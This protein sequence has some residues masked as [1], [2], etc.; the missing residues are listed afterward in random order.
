MSFYFFAVPWHRKWLIQAK[1][2][3]FIWKIKPLLCFCVAYPGN[4]LDLNL[5]TVVLTIMFSQDNTV[6]S[7]TVENN[8][9]QRSYCRD[10][11]SF[12]WMCETSE[13]LTTHGSEQQWQPSTGWSGIL[14]RSGIL[15][16]PTNQRM[17]NCSLSL[18][19]FFYLNYTWCWD[20]SYSGSGCGECIR[21]PEVKPARARTQTQHSPHSQSCCIRSLGAW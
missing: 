5:L 8:S 6:V 2:Y 15:Y 16:H 21:L 17:H 19:T 3:I 13:L 18:M 14:H 9:R 20:C 7:R 12:M 11:I 1:L 4:G 10:G